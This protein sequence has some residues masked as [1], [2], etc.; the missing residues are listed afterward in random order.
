MIHTLKRSSLRA[1]KHLGVGHL[2]ASSVW[3]RSRLLILCYHGVAM[4]NEHEWCPGLHVSAE[5]LE[6]RLELIQRHRCRVLSLDDAIA[7]LYAGT[8][9][10]RSVVLTFDDGYYDFKARAWPLLRK[11][12]FPA[13]V[14]VTT[15]RVDH[16][17]PNVN[18]FISYAIWSSPLKRFD[19]RGLPG[20]DGDYD[21]TTAAE[22]HRVAQRIVQALQ[23]QGWVEHRHDQLPRRDEVARLVTER[24]GLDYNALLERRT[25]TLMRPEELRELGREGVDFQL[26]THVHRTPADPEE[27]LRDVMLNR[28]RLE[29]MTGT[30]P[31]HLCYPSGNYRPGYLPVLRRYGIRSATTCDPGLATCASDPLLLPRFVDTGGVSSIVFEAWLTGMAACLPRRTTRGGDRVPSATVQLGRQ[32]NVLSS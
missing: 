18:L 28:E 21:F 17:L 31:I 2:V 19:G 14:Y 4:D 12:G 11:Y 16:N 9:P 30:S 15:G 29:A 32:S 13:T 24:A 8:L 6:R 26:H 25:L 20:L 23:A 5:H 1:L 10:D 7:R 27:F 22:R 3:R